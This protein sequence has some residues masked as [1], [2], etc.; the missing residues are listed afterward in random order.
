MSR[1]TLTRYE[2]QL[3]VFEQITAWRL[4]VT[5]AALDADADPYIF[6]HLLT[7][8]DILTGTAYADFYSVCGPYE[9]AT[10][11]RDSP[12]DGTPFPFFRLTEF[13]IEL[14]N[15]VI[16]DE[17]WAFVVAEANRLQEGLKALD[18][19]AA[20]TTAVVG[21]ASGSDSASDSHSDS[22]SDS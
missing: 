6:L 8:P 15:P 16:A 17:A 10:Y 1:L 21:P 12:V 4:R 13:T 7:P 9:L 19:M 14:P 2:P 22:S 20:V 3:V 11:P 5:C 18:S